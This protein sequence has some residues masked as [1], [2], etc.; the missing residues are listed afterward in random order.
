WVDAVYRRS[1][2]RPTCLTRSLVLY[3][4][5]RGRGIPCRLSIGLRRQ[6]ATLDG[7]AWVGSAFLPEAA[8][9]DVFLSF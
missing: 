9:F 2:F 5:L 8:A 7:H 3:R 1:P 4:I 6:H